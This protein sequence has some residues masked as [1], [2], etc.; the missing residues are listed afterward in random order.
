VTRRRADR[1]ARRGYFAVGIWHPKNSANTG[2]LLRSAWLYGAAFVFT[3]GCRYDR[4]ASDTVSTPH[5]VPLLHFASIT[6]LAAHLPWSAALVGVELTDDAVPLAGFRHPPR[7][8]YL[9]GAEDHG[10]PPAV[11]DR[12]HHL[13]RIETPRP[14]SLNVACAGTVVLH[15][16]HSVLA[17]MSPAAAT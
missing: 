13:V 15:H 7:A 3:V 1:D 4:Q 9:L 2:S 17:A 5:A 10:L 14:V 16:R 6:D 11:L 8:C 12:C